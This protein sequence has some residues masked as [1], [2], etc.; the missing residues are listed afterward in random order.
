ML[1]LNNK[2]IYKSIVDYVMRNWNSYCFPIGNFLIPKKIITKNKKKVDLESNRNKLLNQA[3]S[4]Y[5]KNMTDYLNNNSIYFI[6]ELIV[7]IQN[8]ELWE[9]LIDTYI[10]LSNKQQKY[11]GLN[12]I[13]LDYYLPNCLACIEVDSNFHIRKTDLDFVRDKYL[14]FE[15][16]IKTI[17]FFHFG[18]NTKNDENGIKELNNLLKLEI[19]NPNIFNYSEIIVNNFIYE[20]EYII[21][22]LDRF[23][24]FIGQTRIF[25]EKYFVITEYDYRCFSEGLFNFVNPINFVEDF[26]NLSYMILGINI[27]VCKNIMNYSIKE[28]K[29]ILDN[30][31]NP[32]L[33]SQIIYNY[34]TIPYWISAIIKISDN[35]SIRKITG[36]DRFILKYLNDEIIK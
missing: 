21:I 16:K 27:L 9:V 7:I 35:K 13:S 30:K 31:D 18:E 12:Y 10:P 20:N 11:K 32:N 22:I 33:E 26:I 29:Y 6:R 3:T 25:S 1:N 34:K 28:I 15:Y 5:A 2:F 14:E 23:I 36:E 8:R 17:R 4:P 19:T 24:K